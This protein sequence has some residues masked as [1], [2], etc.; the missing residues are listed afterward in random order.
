VA[1]VKVAKALVEGLK[2]AGTVKLT[3]ADQVQK[4][5]SRE[6]PLIIGPGL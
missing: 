5:S 3:L 2:P 4:P 1:E 6:M